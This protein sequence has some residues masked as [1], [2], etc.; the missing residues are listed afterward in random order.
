[1]I[2]LDDTQEYVQSQWGKPDRIDRM[3]SEYGVTEWW[4]YGTQTPK[5]HNGTVE[6]MHD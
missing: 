5:F 1:M 4:Y 3:V 6:I 2:R